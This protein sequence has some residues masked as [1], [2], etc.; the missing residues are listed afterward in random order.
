MTRGGDNQGAM[1]VPTMP[2]E[3]EPR[4]MLTHYPGDPMLLPEPRLDG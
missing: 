4:R 2:T 3:D 1:I